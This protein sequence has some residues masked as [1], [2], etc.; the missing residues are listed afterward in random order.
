[1]TNV[2]ASMRGDG[3][4]G[5]RPGRQVLLRCVLRPGTVVRPGCGGCGG[6]CIFS[7][8]PKKAWRGRAGP[9]GRG[10]GGI[11]RPWRNAAESRRV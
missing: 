7:P 2:R 8:A 1:M 9:A 6:R 11:T 5:T 3:G 10:R 4:R